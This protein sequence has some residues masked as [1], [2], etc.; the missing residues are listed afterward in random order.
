[1]NVRKPDLTVEDV[2]SRARELCHWAIARGTLVIRSHVDVSDPRLIGVD[3]L[4][5]LR[6]EMAPY[7]DI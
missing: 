6:R 4:L 1:M 3:A 5:A 7:L 2:L